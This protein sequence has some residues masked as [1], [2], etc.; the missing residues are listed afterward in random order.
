MMMDSDRLASITA[1]IV[2][3]VQKAD[4]HWVTDAES[5]KTWDEVQA[6]VEDARRRF[7]EAVIDIP[8]EIPTL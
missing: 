7:P 1:S 8:N 4:C 5:S 2:R 3:G 6:S